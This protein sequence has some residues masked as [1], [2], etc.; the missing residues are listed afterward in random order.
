MDDGTLED[1]IESLDDHVDSLEEALSPLIRSQLVETTS[2]LSL[3]NKAKANILIL[4]TIESLLFSTLKLNGIDAKEHPIFAELARTKT[5][6]EKIKLAE[7]RVAGK[8]GEQSQRGM[9]LDKAA[10]GRFVK[11]ALSGNEKHDREL[12]EA[13]AAERAA[14][15][16]KFEALSA[17]VGTTQ[18]FKGI[19]DT[20][21]VLVTGEKRPADAEP[22]D[23]GKKRKKHKHDGK[24]HKSAKTPRAGNEIF[25]DLLNKSTEK[26]K[27]SRAKGA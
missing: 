10:A 24:K 4:Y 26:D 17:Q 18:R 5:Y 12:A 2:N 23:S 14:A 27:H 1:L 15:D 25:K 20:S 8:D 3:L 6:F 9:S 22:R 19:D 21:E 13:K 7:Q 16:K 11:H